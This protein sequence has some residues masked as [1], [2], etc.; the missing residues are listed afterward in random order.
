[1]KITRYKIQITNTS[2]NTQ[3]KY[4]KYKHELQT[5]KGN[6]KITKYMIQITNTSYKYTNYKQR[7]Y[8]KYKYSMQSIYKIQ[9]QITKY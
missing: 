5:S 3:R 1:M 2:Y 4:E 9:L 7:K 8:K 6:I